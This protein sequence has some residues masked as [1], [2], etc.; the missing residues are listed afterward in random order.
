MLCQMHKHGFFPC[1]AGLDSALYHQPILGSMP[2]TPKVIPLDPNRSRVVAVD[3]ET[4]R[5]I[6]A[7]GGQRLAFDVSTRL[8]RLPPDAGDQPAQILTLIKPREPKK[9]KS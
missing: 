3:R 6:V 9:R 8:T 5:V 2:N 7:I 4:Q 1:V